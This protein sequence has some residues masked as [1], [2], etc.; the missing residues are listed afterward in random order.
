MI[1][2]I[3]VFAGQRMLT[4]LKTKDWSH[5]ACTYASQSDQEAEK[6][7]RKHHI[8]SRR[9]LGASQTLPESWRSFWCCLRYSDV[10]RSVPDA[11]DSVLDADDMFL[12]QKSWVFEGYLIHNSRVSHFTYSLQQKDELWQPESLE[13][14]LNHHSNHE[15]ELRINIVDD[16][17]GD[18]WLIS[19]WSTPGVGFVVSCSCSWLLFTKLNFVIIRSCLISYFKHLLVTNWSNYR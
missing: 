8:A 11:P 6:C 13:N 16:Y 4:K 19:S 2:V 15:I 1:M 14:H 12:S 7:T 5:P 9:C 18:V 3:C 10:P 17:D